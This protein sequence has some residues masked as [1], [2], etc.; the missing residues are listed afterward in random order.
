MLG[1]AVNEYVKDAKQGYSKLL[2]RGVLMQSN[3]LSKMLRK[4]ATIFEYLVSYEVSKI[5]DAV[6]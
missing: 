3:Q 2:F 1:F 6:K 5:K 4:P